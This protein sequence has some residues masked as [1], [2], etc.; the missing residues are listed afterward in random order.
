MTD[1]GSE[2][3]Q[4]GDPLTSAPTSL[5]LGACIR[6]ELGA[7]CLRLKS[8]GPPQTL[9]VTLGEF[10]SLGRDFSSCELRQGT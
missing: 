6:P 7:S 5:S 8:P 9:C 10:A 4:V 3:G 2:D 1:K